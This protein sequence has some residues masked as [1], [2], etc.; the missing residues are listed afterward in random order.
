MS[1]PDH[2]TYH[3][4]VPA[5]L[6]HSEAGVPFSETY[7]DVYHTA[8]GAL[9]QARH[10]F[11]GGNGLPERWRGRECFT[12]LE[13]GFGIGLNF[14]A[15]WAAWAADA[16]ACQRLHFVS[17]EKHPFRREDLAE[18]QRGYPE[19]APLAAELLA[20]WPVLTP[21]IH[22]LHLAGGRLTLTLALGDAQDLLPQLRLAADAFYLDGF[23]PAKNP[24]LWTPYIFRGLAR[25]AA[26]GATLA[27]WSVAASVREGLQA[28][29]FVSHKT[30][31]FGGKRDMLQGAYRGPGVRLPAR[32]GKRVLVIGA[33][34]AGTSVAHRLAA[35]DFEVT[36]LDQAPGPGC[37]ASGN[38]V[39]VLRPLPSL[40]DN[41]LSRL[42]RTAFLYTRQHLLS[43]SEAGL[44]VRWGASGVLHLARDKTH[45]ATQRQVAETFAAPELFRFVD[46]DEA[47]R[48]IG[49]SVPVGG[50]HFSSGGWGMPPSLCQANLQAFPAIHQHYDQRV[51]RLEPTADGWAAYAA[52]GNLLLEADQVVLANAADA[53]RL[54]GADWLPLRSARG[55]TTL[56]PEAATP[57]LDL[58]V[59]RLGYVTPALDGLRV[60]G[61]S[62]LAGDEDGE[63]RLEEHRDNL[64]KLNFILPGFAKGLPAE[65]L[66]GRVGFRPISPDRLP[67]LGPLPENATPAAGSRLL[68]LPRR[69][70]LWLASGFGA[71]G[72][73]WSAWAGE[74]LA[75]QMASEPLPVEGDLADALDPGRFLLKPVR[76][77][78]GER[79]GE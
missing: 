7:G 44:P 29:G 73:V 15:T 31:G 2:D 27:T 41:R 1:L 75:S 77:G 22:R 10:V 16:Q 25:C 28:V 13:T 54:A 50:W 33:G 51:E 52:D 24:E 37:G 55:Q 36:L 30:P 8:A 53:K 48:L 69:P 65:G 17:L 43:L 72:F 60:C 64:A 67:M 78:R 46:A 74:F 59:C 35:R 68:T 49:W 57:P 42:T 45:E 6:C 14:L 9:G 63:E 5:R 71:R 18:L 79:D 34:F 21:G 40:D 11:L 38:R 66:S 20:Q 56:L 4:I 47:S 62:F 26:A 76:P 19:L 61:A 32:R 58:V 39:G 3:P 23:S 12:I 70:G